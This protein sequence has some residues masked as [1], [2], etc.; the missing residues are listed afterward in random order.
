MSAG[1]IAEQRHRLLLERREDELAFGALGERGARLGVDDLDEEVI[2]VHVEAVAHLEAL[3]RDARP[4]HLGEPV[5]VHG[6]EAR[7]GAFDLCAQTVRPRLAAEQAE[8]ELQRRRVDA[9]VL[10]RLRDHER[11]GRCRD[12]HLRAEVVQEHRLPRGEAAR[13]RE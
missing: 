5:E 13:D 9:R 4:A 11:V 7:Q 10:H 12:E 8:L 2:L 1:A 6:A 3:R